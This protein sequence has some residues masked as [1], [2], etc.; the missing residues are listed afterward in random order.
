MHI[1]N[2]FGH[3]EGSH[4]LITA[5]PPQVRDDVH[6]PKLK[7]NIPPFEGRYIPDIYLTWE[8]ESEQ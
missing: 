4:V 1:C 8:L 2:I 3:I 7:L 5:P 6:I